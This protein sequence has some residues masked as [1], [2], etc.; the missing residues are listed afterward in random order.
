[1]NIKIVNRI[2]FADLVER[3]RKVPLVKKSE[4]GSEIFVY[5]KARISLRELDPD[6]VNPTTFYL[7]KEN[8]KFQEDLRKHLQE[9]EGIDTL[10]L[11]IGLEIVNEVNEVWTLMPPI[12]EVT[13]RMVRYQPL[14]GELSYEETVKVQIPIIND[15]AH[16]VATARKLGMTFK[17]IFISGADERYPFYAHPNEWERVKLVDSVPKTKGEKKLYSRED[18][19]GLYRNF[20]VLGCGKPRML[21]K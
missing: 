10:L 9:T 13:P 11:D 18:C 20:G 14:E 16:R 7:L 21:G 6:E 1:M 8:L 12:I 17:G 5:D 4:D 19:Y 2:S 3:I 15:G